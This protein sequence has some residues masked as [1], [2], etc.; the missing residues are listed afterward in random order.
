[1]IVNFEKLINKIGESYQNIYD[2]GLIPYKAKQSKAKQSKAKQ[3]KA[4]QNQPNKI[5]R[6]QNIAVLFVYNSDLF[7]VSITFYSIEHAKEIQASL[8][9][10]RLS[11]S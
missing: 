9:R 2:Q 4:K 7:V 3:S 5:N 6:Y 8:E 1:M 11:G 10:I